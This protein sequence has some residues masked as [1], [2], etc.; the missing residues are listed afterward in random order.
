M[1]GVTSAVEKQEVSAN[2]IGST[3]IV[4]GDL[5]LPV[6]KVVTIIGRKVHEGPG[7]NQFRVT[8]V[9]G[10]TINMGI[11]VR[12][13]EEWPDGTEATLKGAEVGTLKFLTKEM[14]NYGKD[15]PRWKAP[16]QQLFLEFVVD[17]IVSPANLR[18]PKR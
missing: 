18:L 2:A 7:G 9:D 17:N 6:G 13:I 14:T 12:G 15:D 11:N 3:I 8:S 5:G 1:L 10:R 4:I 16:H